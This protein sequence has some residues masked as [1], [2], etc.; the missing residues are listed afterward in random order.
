MLTDTLRRSPR[1]A[2]TVG[3]ATPG[4]KFLMQPQRTA[5]RATGH[6]RLVQK[7]RRPVLYA[8]IRRPDRS[9]I[10][11]DGKLKPR[12]VNRH[13][14]ILGGI[15]RR[16]AKRWGTTCNPVARVDK[17]REPRYGSDLR[18]LRPEEVQAVV[19]Q[20]TSAQWGAVFLTAA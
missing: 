9:Q 5:A 14:T 19:R 20:A 17:L 18:Y 13:T 3:G 2:V 16:A 10:T 4:G 8:P 11:A 6:V 12:T 15:F 1:T 7:A